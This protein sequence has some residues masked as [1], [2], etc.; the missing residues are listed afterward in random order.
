MT[1]WKVGGKVPTLL[2][3]LELTSFDPQVI[4]TQEH[5]SLH[6]LIMTNRLSFRNIVFTKI[7][8]QTVSKI[9]RM[10]IKFLLVKEFP[11]LR[12]IDYYMEC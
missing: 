10:F 9:K 2:D 1:F 8:Q 6:H 4:T 12:C 7:R 11:V 5:F 3:P